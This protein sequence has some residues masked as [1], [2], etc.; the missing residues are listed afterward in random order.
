MDKNNNTRIEELF[1][2]AELMLNSFNKMPAFKWQSKISPKD[3]LNKSFF[4][5]IDTGSHEAEFQVWEKGL[6]DLSIFEKKL[7]KHILDIHPKIENTNQLAQWIDIL[8]KILIETHYSL[9]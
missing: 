5:K 7:I 2:E 1:T 4:I 3:I 9:D 6:A 8:F